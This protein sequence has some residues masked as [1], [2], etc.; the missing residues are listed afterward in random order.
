MARL[1]AHLRSVVLHHA[2]HRERAVVLYTDD[3]RRYLGEAV[4]PTGSATTLALCPR[5]ILAR[6]FALGASGMILAH[7]HPSGECRPSAADV[8]ATRRLIWL[9]QMVELVLLDHLIVT[10]AEAYSMRLAGLV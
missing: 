2:D 9:G 5:V 10:R 4:L 3:A 1:L 8:Q 7:N 6:G